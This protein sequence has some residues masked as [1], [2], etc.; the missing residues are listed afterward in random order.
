VKTCKDSSDLGYEGRGTM[1]KELRAYRMAEKVM[2]KVN[3]EANY[4]EVLKKAQEMCERF[5]PNP[6]SHVGDEY[7][8]GV[9]ANEI[10]GKTVYY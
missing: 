2:K 6:F 1:G 10:L 5:H 7:A 8:A 3:N 9:I 4:S